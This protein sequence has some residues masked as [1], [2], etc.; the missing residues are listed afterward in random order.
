MSNIITKKLI[1]EEKSCKKEPGSQAILRARVIPK[2]GTLL[3]YEKK[4]TAKKPGLLRK[5]P[6]PENPN[7]NHLD[8]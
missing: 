7:Q 2:E 1:S 8:S 5:P 6:S 4:E 3:F